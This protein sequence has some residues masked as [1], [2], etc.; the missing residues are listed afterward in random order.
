LPFG[1]DGGLFP[2]LPPEGFAVVLGPFGG[3]VP[4]FAMIFKIKWK[5][6]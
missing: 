4:V 3:L 1:V 5:G 6:I 2:R